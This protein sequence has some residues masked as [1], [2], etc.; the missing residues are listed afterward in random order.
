MAVALIMQID[1]HL[2]PSADDAWMAWAGGLAALFYCTRRQQRDDIAVAPNAQYTCAVWLAT[3]LVAWECAWQ[4]RMEFPQTGWS[5][6]AWGAVPAIAL[7]L[8]TRFGARFA[9]WGENFGAF[10]SL[11]LGPLAVYGL[12]W[13]LLSSANPSKDRK[14]TRLNSSH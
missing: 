5:F 1:R 4:L 12:L 11:G 2:H 3:G 6:A 10:R 14:S 13:S 8:L 7:V 9:P